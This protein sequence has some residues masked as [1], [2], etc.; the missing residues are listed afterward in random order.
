MKK[1]AIVFG[2]G[3]A[4]AFSVANA[5]IKVT[6]DN[7]Q[8][9]TGMDV[10]SSKITVHNPVQIGG[11]TLQEEGTQ[12]LRFGTGGY[13]LQ[14]GMSGM[15]VPQSE[16]NS[17]IG[18]IVGSAAYLR[19]LGN[20]GAD[21]GVSSAWF[22]NLYV[23]NVTELGSKTISD[24]RYKENIKDL[25]E[26]LEDVLSLRP[27]SFDFKQ[28]SLMPDTTGLK[29]KVGF[30]AQ[31]VKEVFPGLVGYMED[32]DR[33]TLDY[34]SIIPYLVKAL[35]EE[36]A[37]KELLEEE[38]EVMRQEMAGL[39]EAVDA[40]MQAQGLGG[41]NTKAPGMQNEGDGVQTM[42]GFKLYQNSPN[43]FSENTVIRYELPQGVTKASIGVFDMQGKQVLEQAL[44]Q[45]DSGKMEISA[46]SLRPGMYTYSLL[47]SGK[48]M[49][50]KKMVVTE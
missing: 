21:L 43:P 49:D 48:V 9:G 38:M 27:V 31:E 17:I 6:S 20:Y 45:G 11:Y 46:G 12:D 13:G 39:Q 42:A 30:L 44:P 19:P 40:L 41:N 50:S 3:M 29:G 15:V 1:T 26:S 8:I 33:Y 7:I 37:E 14:F 10:G 18:E 16:T 32:I 22:R 4:M 5:Q 23:K 47:L 24:A 28:D 2:F 25:S 36:H 34:Q 35:Q